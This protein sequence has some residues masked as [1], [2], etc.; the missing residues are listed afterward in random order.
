MNTEMIQEHLKEAISRVM[1]TMFFLPVQFQEGAQGLKTWFS[2]GAS[3]LEA[4]VEFAGPRSGKVFLLVPVQGLKEMAANILGLDDDG[5]SNE[6]LQDTLKEAINMIAGRMLS[7]VDTE[8]ACALGIPRLV[9]EW[10]GKD[11][12]D[13]QSPGAFLLF[14]TARDHLAA[15][16]MES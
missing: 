11:R 10:N 6:H 7:L 3:V 8:G 4:S 1:E 2:P 15:G 9:G 13:H 12:G 16:I 14:E 5:L